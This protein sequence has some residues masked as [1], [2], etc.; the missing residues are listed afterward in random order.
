MR[1]LILAVPYLLFI[2]ASVKFSPEPTARAWVGCSLD[3]KGT[4]I[5]CRVH[6][7][8]CISNSCGNELAR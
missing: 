1:K 5:Q 3:I 4:P 2:A 6:S 8:I 7:D